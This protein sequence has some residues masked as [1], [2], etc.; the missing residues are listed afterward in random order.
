MSRHTVAAYRRDLHR[1]ADYLAEHGVTDPVEVTSAMIGSYA[2]RLREGIAE[3]DGNGWAETPL[4]NASVARA[5]IAVRSMHRFAA[6]EGLTDE[7]PARV[8]RPPKPPKRLPKALSLAT[9]SGYACG[10]G[11]RQRTRRP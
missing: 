3:P 10:P 4:A 1:Y 6:A 9:G 7:D 8:I 5:V 2:A 11:D